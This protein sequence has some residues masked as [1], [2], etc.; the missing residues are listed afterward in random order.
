MIFRKNLCSVY[1]LKN[2]KLCEFYAHYKRIN[3]LQYFNFC[4]IFLNLYK[5]T[6]FFRIWKKLLNYQMFTVFFWKKFVHSMQ[7]FVQIANPRNNFWTCVANFIVE[8]KRSTLVLLA[9]QFLCVFFSFRM[10]HC[11]VWTFLC[12]LFGNWSI[13]FYYSSSNKKNFWDKKF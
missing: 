12:F 1:G 5:C 10:T 9:S 8:R 6:V 11:G 3:G 7:L 13:L 4:K 2:L